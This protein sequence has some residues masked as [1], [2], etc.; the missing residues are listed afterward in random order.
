MSKMSTD[1]VRHALNG[2][3]MGTRWSAIV[4]CAP[5]I[6]PPP[7]RAALAAAVDEIDRQ[8]SPRKPE[9][10]LM[11]VNRATP[12]TWVDVPAHILNVLEAGLEIGRASDCAFDIGMGDAVAAWGFSAADPDPDQIRA[13]IRVI[14]H[15]AHEVLEIDRESA[16]VR[17]HAPIAL[18]LCGIAK[19]YGVDRLA[20]TVRDFGIRHALLSIDGEVRALGSLPDDNPWVIGVERPD[21]DCRA[22]HSI[23]TLTETSV[24]TSGDYRHRVELA[25]NHFAHIMDPNRG[26]P[27]VA[28][29]VSATVV[30]PSC[31]QADAWAT[32]MMVLG[33]DRGMRLA[34]D[35]GL[36]VLFLD[37]RGGTLVPLKTGPVFG[38]GMRLDMQA[39]ALGSSMPE[40]K[41]QK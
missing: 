14:R 9:S 4:H 34:R 8:M 10:D 30:A 31:M 25:G 23:L 18:D 38:C 22:A 27:L 19:G 2:P 29:S 24:A 15:P 28:C 40:A 1:L 41:A 39:K 21:P 13:A 17:K 35:L 32:A 12:G 37:R 26:A 36:S 5:G 3:T 16:R 11:R 20:E 6:D 7:I 33:P